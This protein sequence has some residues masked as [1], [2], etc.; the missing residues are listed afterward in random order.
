MSPDVRFRNAGFKAPLTDNRLGNLPRAAVSKVHLLLFKQLNPTVQMR[1]LLRRVFRRK[2]KPLSAADRAI[3]DDAIA[4]YVARNAT[5]IR[6][7]MILISQIQRSGGSLVSQ[8]FDS[9]PAIAAHPHE[10]TIGYP[11]G[12]DWIRTPSSARQSFREMFENSHLRLVREGF[13]KGSKSDERF[14]FIF[15]PSVQHRV[16]MKAWSDHSKRGAA[17]A[18]FTSFFN[19]WINYT[20]NLSVSY[21]T[22]FAP[23]MANH[24]K[25]VSSYFETYPDGYLIQ[26]VRDPIGW[27]ASSKGHKRWAG[28]P[29]E[30]ILDGWTQSALSI[31][32]NKTN[33]GDRVIV[34]GFESLLAD[35]HR[36]MTKLCAVLG[37]DFSP[38]LTIPTFNGH[39]LTANSSFAVSGKGII[40]TPRNR[41]GDLTDEEIRL[42][43]RQCS[44]IFERMQSF[45]INH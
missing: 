41:S 29:P 11:T 28:Q 25:S 43:R 2:S 9:H 45:C 17:N 33:F 27:F 14:P 44:A 37:L 15:S 23:R 32:R 35:P 1:K 20:G 30:I 39:P 34:I 21:V 7:P 6:C 26:V 8:L 22:A 42:V 3:R 16:F 12:E 24:A 40:D 31:E 18:F 5:M 36:T 10:L 4:E 13:T 19:A 38:T